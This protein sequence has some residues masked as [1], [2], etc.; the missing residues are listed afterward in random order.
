MSDAFFGSALNTKHQPSKHA[1]EQLAR[2]MRNPFPA[3]EVN[4]TVRDKLLAFGFIEIKPGTSPF[5]SHK[6]GRLVDF[7][8]IT[9]KGAAA[10]A[11][12]QLQ[13]KK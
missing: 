10:L 8:H 12:W 13:G 1:M 6:T 4:F 5:T 9:M 2:V 3:Q 7:M 11:A